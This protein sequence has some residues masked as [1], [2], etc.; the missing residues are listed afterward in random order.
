MS[1]V[2]VGRIDMKHVS[3]ETSNMYGLYTE[4][5]LFI[6]CEAERV[7][8]RQCTQRDLEVP[9]TEA[10]YNAIE[11][12]RLIEQRLD[13]RLNAR[14][15]EQFLRSSDGQDLLGKICDYD[16]EDGDALSAIVGELVGEEK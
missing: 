10:Q 12:G 11:D 13:G 7:W 5:W 8:I 14:R 2:S 16:D 9:Q 1:K 3:D 4:T 6:D 15:I